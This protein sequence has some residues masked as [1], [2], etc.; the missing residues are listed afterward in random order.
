MRDEMG[1]ENFGSSYKPSA[2]AKGDTCLWWNA[3][4]QG[5]TQF[6]SILAVHGLV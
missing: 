6:A 2:E 1:D 5:M 3:L 4:S